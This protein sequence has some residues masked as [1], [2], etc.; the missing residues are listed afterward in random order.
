MKTLYKV[1]FTNVKTGKKIID[2]F[3]KA[4]DAK[5]AISHANLLYPKTGIKAELV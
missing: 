2:G 5:N 3:A 4:K 1:K